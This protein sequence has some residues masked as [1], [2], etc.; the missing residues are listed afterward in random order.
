MIISRV[1]A[2]PNSET[3]SVPDIGH[4]VKRYLLNSK[5][6]VDPFARNKRW[7]TY[8][9]DLN[10]DTVAQYHYE[11]A[12][13]MR[14]LA[15]HEV[16]CDLLILDPPYSPRQIKECY[17]G[18]GRKMQ[19][20]DAQTG[21]LWGLWKQAALGILTSDAT[22]L[23][24]GWNSCGMGKEMGFDITEIMLVNHGVSHN[25]TICMAEKRDDRQQVIPL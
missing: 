21:R 7:A 4:F 24:F 13:F 14:H 6:S 18:I 8:T 5:V 17:D 11:A 19:M 15:G 2:M 16:K 22:V 1:W 20:E 23:S 9:N 3:F 12:D 25:D 10:P